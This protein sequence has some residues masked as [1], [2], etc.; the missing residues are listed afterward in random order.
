M[1]EQTVMSWMGHRNSRRVR[2][3]FHLHDQDAQRQMNQIKSVGG[4]DAM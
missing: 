2:H 4:T 1:P 3:Y